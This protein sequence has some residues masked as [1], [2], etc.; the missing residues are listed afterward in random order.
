MEMSIGT[1]LGKRIKEI[2]E[3][4]H[5]KQVE[6]ANMIEIEP[7]NLSKIEK[8]AHFPKDETLYKIIKA[9]DVDIKDLFYFEHIQPREELIENIIRI[10]QK[11]KPEELQFFYRILMAYR[12]TKHG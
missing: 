2:R 12:D 11:S 10:L 3:A 5:L 9:L 4:K 1:L 6:L 7:T 8:G